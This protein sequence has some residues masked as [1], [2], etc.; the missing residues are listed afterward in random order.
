MSQPQTVNGRARRK[1][2]LRSDSTIRHAES[3]I[4]RVFGLPEECV[5][6]VNPNGRKARADKLIRALLDDYG[7][8]D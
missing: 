2:R 6:L 8:W 1:N 7:W 3:E 5:R 4:A